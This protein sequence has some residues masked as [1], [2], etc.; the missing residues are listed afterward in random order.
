MSGDLWAA[1]EGLLDQG[2]EGAAQADELVVGVCGRRLWHPELWGRRRRGWAWRLD[3]LCLAIKAEAWPLLMG[4][5]PFTLDQRVLVDMV[6]GDR[7]R[8]LLAPKEAVSLAAIS[9]RIADA[10]KL[11]TKGYRPQAG[12]VLRAYLPSSHPLRSLPGEEARR[13]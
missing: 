12:D 2:P 7:L 9:P 1:L 11:A 3:E 4:R 8:R 6:R 5:E 10:A 13:G